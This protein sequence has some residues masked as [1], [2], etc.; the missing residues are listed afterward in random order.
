MLTDSPWAKQARI[1][2]GSPTEGALPTGAPVTIPGCGSE[3][4]DA[5]QRVKVTITWS[6]A[7][8][9]KQALVRQ[10]V[11]R[12]AA[13]LPDHE[14]LLA[15]NEPFYAVSVVGLPPGFAV[16]GSM[17]DAIRSETMLK[18]KNEEPIPPEQIQLF[19]DEADQSIRAMFLFPKTDAITLDDKDVE[20]ITKFGD[21]DVKKKFKLEDMVFEGQLA[22]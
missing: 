18:R 4:F 12:D 2:I 15:Q 14:Q 7:L 17:V 19:R 16:F 11:G 9:I 10:V 13:L 20:F 22:L 6:S 21:T 1:V 3:Q 8:P 5:I